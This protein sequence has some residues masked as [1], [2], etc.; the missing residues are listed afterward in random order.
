MNN[1]SLDEEETSVDSIV[2]EILDIVDNDRD[3]EEFKEEFWEKYMK[4]NDKIKSILPSYYYNAMN[5]KAHNILEKLA[6]NENDNNA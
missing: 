1:L 4:Y 3:E 2:V 5:A 6:M